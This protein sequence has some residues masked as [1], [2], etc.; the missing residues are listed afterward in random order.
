MN[1]RLKLRMIRNQQ[2]QLKCLIKGAY[3]AVFCLLAQAGLAQSVSAT[4]NPNEILIGDQVRMELD[5]SFPTGITMEVADLSVIEKTEGI[6]LLKVYPIDTIPAESGTLL[7]QTLLITSFDSGQYMIPQIPVRFL[8]GEQPQTATTNSLLLIVNPY[9]I[10]Q[11]TVQLQ[12][13]KG[14]VSEAKTI[15]DYLPII[16]GIA[17]VGLIGLLIYFIYKRQQRKE[18]PEAVVI[19]RPPFEVAIEK[20]GQLREAKLWQQN[21]IK[22]YQSELTF[23]LR[24]YLEER[25]HIKALEST[26]D[27]IITDLKQLD[28]EDNWQ[29]ELSKILHTADL[30]KFA[31][32]I[33]PVEIHAAGL[34]QLETFVRATKPKPKPV[35]EEK[36]PE[37][38]EDSTAPE[39]KDK[40]DN[41]AEALE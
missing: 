10:S 39:E 34:E 1:G 9:P 4:L 8:R 15:E 36:E 19:K 20:I 7:H 30:V 25:F 12:P 28:I 5:F 13:I 29:E 6:E 33:P 2:W 11:D 35:E 31:K 26:S 16:I 3:L 41:T 38:T 21:K 32:A 14:I 24:E 18:I 17:S 23:I 22:E 37:D 40:L 27:E